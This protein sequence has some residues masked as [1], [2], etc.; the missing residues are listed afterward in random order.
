VTREDSQ[1]LLAFFKQ[2]RID[3]GSFDAGIDLALRRLLTSPKF[4]FRV[5]REPAAVAAGGA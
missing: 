4:I 1:A 3:G 5:E 2:G